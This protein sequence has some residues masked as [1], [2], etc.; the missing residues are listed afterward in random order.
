MADHAEAHEADS[1]P[2]PASSGAD[3]SGVGVPASNSLQVRAKWY[4]WRGEVVHVAHLLVEYGPP[5]DRG[6]FFRQSLC[7]PV[8]YLLLKLFGKLRVL[9]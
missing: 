6:F 3:P 7:Q 9:G 2:P 8:R 1:M 4:R 5:F